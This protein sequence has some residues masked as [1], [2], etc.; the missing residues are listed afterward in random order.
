MAVAMLERGHIEFVQAQMLPWRRI[1][2]GLARPDVEYKL[3]SRDPADGACSVLMRYPP[4]WSREGP[5]HIL[6]DEEFYVLDGS[7]EIDGRDYPAD[8]YAY[9]PA[10]WTRQAMASPNGCVILA[11]YD[12]EPAL[13]GHAGD[14]SAENSLRA[15][16]HIDA[17]AMPW[18]LS[19]NDPNLRHLGIGRKNLR[20]DPVTGERAFLS[21]ILPQAVPPGNEGPQE[22]HPVVEEAY[23]IGGSLTGP[24]GTMYP[25]AYFWRPPGIA[26]GPF[27]ARWGAVSLIRFVGGRH[28]N[29]WTDSKAG[30]S[31]DA[32]YA[33]VLPPQL[34]HLAATPWEPG[35]VW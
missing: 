17:A 23:V 12:R 22:I 29:I 13:I 2:P 33:P 21:L 24:H 15:I 11:F 32:P 8:S 20:T 10:G 4:G 6:A 7:L 35:P 30:F 1:G 18:D 25:G 5:E 19:L 9:L 16:K 26:H 27:G 14:G 3:L 34:A 31:F 28:L